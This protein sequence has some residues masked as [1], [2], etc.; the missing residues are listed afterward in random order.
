L[1]FPRWEPSSPRKA[2][3]SP[4]RNNPKPGNPVFPAHST[5]TS[6]TLNSWPPDFAAST[7]SVYP[8]GTGKAAILPTVA[9]KSRLVRWLSASISQ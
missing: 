2:Q 9:P 3:L 4:C 8:V 6:P 1:H 7:V 5:N